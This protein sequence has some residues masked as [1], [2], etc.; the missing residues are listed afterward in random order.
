MIIFSGIVKLFSLNLQMGVI[1]ESW[2]DVDMYN[3]DKIKVRRTLTDMSILGHIKLKR[4]FSNTLVAIATTKE[5]W[6]TETTKH[7]DKY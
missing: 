2:A 7:L 4:L 3:K 5:M 1:P 6:A